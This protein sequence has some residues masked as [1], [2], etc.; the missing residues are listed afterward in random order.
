[1]IFTGALLLAT[2]ALRFVGAA[3]VPD[4]PEKILADPAV[5]QH[6]AVIAAFRDV[7]RNLSAL[8]VNTTRDGLSF[9]I[10]HAS[11]HGTVFSFN[12]GTLKNNETAGSGNAVTSDSI[13]RIISVSKNFATFSALVQENQTAS[14]ASGT[15][16]AVLTMN[17]PV[18]RLL[19]EFT[20]PDQD[21]RD[22]GRD[23]TLT[24]LASHTS[25]LSRESYSTDFNVIIGN[26]K[27]SA[28]AIGADWAAVTP[29]SALQNAKQ[30]RLMFAP[31]QQAAYSNA[32]FS[33]LGSAVVSYYNSLHSTALTWPALATQ[34]IFAPFNMTSSFFGS[35]PNAHVPSIAIPGGPHWADLRMGLGYEPAAGMWSS[36]NDLAK[37]LHLGWLSSS[38]SLITLSQR[39]RMLKPLFSLPDGRQL[40]G[41]G[42]E[43]DLY[44]VFTSRNTTAAL[45]KTYASYGKA[46][47]GGGYHAWID[48]IPNLGYGMVVLSQH[49]GLTDYVRIVPTSIRDSVHDIM[50]PAFA[51]AVVARVESRFA[52]L[53]TFGTDTGLTVDQVNTTA[54]GNTTTYA[55]L[56]VQEQMLYL[57]EL[58]VNGTNALESLDRLDWT[59]E[60]QGRL[61][62]T[63]EG[64]A[65]VPSEGASENA[66]FGEGTQVW[67]MMIPGL[68]V[69]DWF[70][71]DGYL[72]TN[73]WSLSKVV[74]VEREGR[75][76]LLYPP[77]DIKLS[78][79]NL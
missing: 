46:G 76:D 13:F 78:R 18:R 63:P 20:L 71:F 25:G 51:E 62:S 56:E 61:F 43:I 55:R 60:Y 26:G 3:C 24:M 59:D 42:W 45:A 66:Q 1:M 67:R 12:N 11:A 54:S 38:P 28:E 65:L 70:D 64:A 16:Y 53:Y 9:A 39:R 19:P 34:S 73:A 29:E 5:L 17:S 52:G 35:I 49:S 36:A 74:L 57:R 6:P 30:T 37:Y 27:A 23:I 22:G 4:V 50:M 31:A 8:Y 69:C 14:I 2:Q 77:F 44:K 72:G 10:V 41:A 40:V 68:D 32:G 75:V 7:E 15:D 33:I 21:W 48:V 79:V 47:D 58:V